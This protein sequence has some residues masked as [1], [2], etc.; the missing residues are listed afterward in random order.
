MEGKIKCRNVKQSI[1]GNINFYW[2]KLKQKLIKHT[3][4]KIKVKKYK[5]TG[6]EMNYKWEKLNSILEWKI[7]NKNH[8]LVIFNFNCKRPKYGFLVT[9]ENITNWFVCFY[10]TTFD[11]KKSPKKILKKKTLKLL[12]SSILKF[13]LKD[14]VQNVYSI[15]KKNSKRNWRKMKNIYRSQNDKKLLTKNRKLN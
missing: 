13:N 14:K 6:I 12:P 5:Q 3:N 11:K 10:K 7:G 9:K 15:D 1:A 8:G 4:W 2:I